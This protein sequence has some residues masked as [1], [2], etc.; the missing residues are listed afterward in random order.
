MILAAF[1]AIA[2]D[3]SA[4]SKIGENC[5]R[6]LVRS[7]LT[8][9]LKAE[10]STSRPHRIFFCHIYTEINEFR[11]ILNYVAHMRDL[12]PVKLALDLIRTNTP[13]DF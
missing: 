10:V 9:S 1:C 4:Q 2:V 5:L 8:Q 7:T 13:R 6:A 3:S 11:Q 12:Q